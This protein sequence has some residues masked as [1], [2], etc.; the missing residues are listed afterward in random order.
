[1]KAMTGHSHESKRW[2]ALLELLSA[3]L[4]LA[5]AA[6]ITKSGAAAAAGNSDNNGVA[7]LP[8]SRASSGVAS[9]SP[10]ASWVQEV[11]A[12]SVARRV[13]SYTQH[14]ACDSTLP[15]DSVDHSPLCIICLAIEL[16]C[17]VHETSA[18][19]YSQSLGWLPQA[20]PPVTNH[21]F[22]SGGRHY[23]NT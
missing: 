17:L 6:A 20:T 1:M 12:E 5:A 19:Y 22:G 3:E 9:A 15:P 7:K 11:I 21:T 4:A 16:G 8:A 18:F 23:A 10:M 14:V 2:S 13:L